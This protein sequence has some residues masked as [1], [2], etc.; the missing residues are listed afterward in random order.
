MDRSFWISLAVDLLIR[1]L[2]EAMVKY[3]LSEDEGQEVL[4]RCSADL[5]GNCSP[6]AQGQTPLSK[7]YETVSL[8]GS[9]V[10]EELETFF[11]SS[12]PI[13]ANTALEKEAYRREQR[14]L[15]GN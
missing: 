3:G 7:A 9:Q 10:V 11:S 1:I 8:L 14:M 15:L 2:K 6:S 13:V 5:A 12:D 4:S